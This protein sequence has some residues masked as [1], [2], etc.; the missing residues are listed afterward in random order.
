MN[1]LFAGV[2]VASIIG[3]AVYGLLGFYTLWLYSRHH[4][5]DY[6]LPVV[7]YRQLP[8]VTV[9]LPLY[10]EREV[11]ARLI[12]AVAQLDYPRDQFEIQVLDDSTD[13]TTQI[14]AAL[15]AEYAQRGLCISLHHRSNRQGFKAGA[16]AQAL[17]SARGEFIAIFDADFVPLP[18]F[19]LRTI[20]YLM[21][22]PAIG[23]VQARWGHLNSD[24]SSLTGAQAIALDKHFAVE[25]LVRH[26]ADYFPKFNGSAGVWRRACIEQSGGW[27]ADT[28]CED[29]CL[30][31]RAV[32]DGWRFHFA[33]DVVAPAE[34][35]NTI[36]A[37]KTQQAR[38]ALGSTQCLLKYGADIWR[39]KKKPFPA[40]V[41]ALLAMSGYLTHVLLFLLLLVQL[42]LAITATRLPSW[43]YIFSLAG[44]G[45]PILFV[46]AQETLYRNWL[47][48]LRH[49]PTL[50]LIAIG[51]APSNTI[52]IVRALSGRQPSFARTPKGSA[53]SYRLSPGWV[54]VVEIGLLTYLIATLLIII[55]SHNSGPVILL[56]SSIL[57]LGYVVAG[58]I[59]E[60]AAARKG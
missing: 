38:W 50:L 12:S 6:P 55:R 25:Q 49:F 18:D 39:T 19:L 26:R 29:L 1:A 30:S 44:I 11:V 48:R 8:P 51:T 42:P 3:L 47:T 17:H 4:A 57:G 24:D 59:M 27:E 60:F 46:L 36:L 40:R 21:T 56:A 14:A 7:D 35:P 15:V 54:L 58:G 16:L 10:N 37:Y 33:N 23:V 45:Q 31:T 9:Q 53:R 28:V 41:Y 32:L 43:L 13:E 52:A 22:E 2:H 20:P 5:R 34:L